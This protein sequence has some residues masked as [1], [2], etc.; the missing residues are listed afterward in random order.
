M[1]SSFSRRN[2]GEAIIKFIT[3]ENLLG[4][5]KGL[6]L[7]IKK[8]YFIL[9]LDL[10]MTW[11]IPEFYNKTNKQINK[12]KLQACRQ[13]EH[14]LQRGKLR[15]AS[16]FSSG[17]YSNG[18]NRLLKEKWWPSTTPG[19]WQGKK[20]KCVGTHKIYHPYNSH[21]KTPV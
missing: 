1:N 3:K 14:Y 18:S 12:T 8:A 2:R 21:S 7:Q 13:K 10:Y 4:P 19:S 15:E 16:D 6:N 9:D 20:K 5:K 11:Y 17:S